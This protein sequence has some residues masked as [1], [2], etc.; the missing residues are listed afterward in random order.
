MR[1]PR[2]PVPP[3]QANVHAK[4]CFHTGQAQLPTIEV[5]YT[6]V[7]G[8]A[9]P[10]MRVAVAFQ[11]IIRNIEGENFFVGLRCASV[12]SICEYHED[13]LPLVARAWPRVRGPRDAKT[14]LKGDGR[15]GSIIPSIVGEC[16]A[17]RAAK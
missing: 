3:R 10:P 4:A 5:P 9:C 8:V 6:I 12:V 1:K 16:S 14:C 2:G 11:C 17:N 15:Y 13:I 7:T